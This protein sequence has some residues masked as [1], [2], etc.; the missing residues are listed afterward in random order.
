MVDITSSK[1]Y[2]QVSLQN[3]SILQN[4]YYEC[5]SLCQMMG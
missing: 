4:T 1:N 2:F 3:V 5:K